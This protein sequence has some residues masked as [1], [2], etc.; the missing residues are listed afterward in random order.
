MWSGTRIDDFVVRASDWRIAMRMI[1]AAAL[2]A[3]A[4]GRLF[5]TAQ[6][7]LQEP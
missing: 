5:K 4:M 2:L 7:P 3:F 1:G 6:T